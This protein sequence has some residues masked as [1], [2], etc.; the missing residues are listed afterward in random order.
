[1]QGGFETF[2][3]SER[4]EGCGSRSSFESH[5][6]VRTSEPRLMVTICRDITLIVGIMSIGRRPLRIEC[7]LAG[8]LDFPYTAAI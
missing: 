8:P 2:D 5:S 7:E 1:M 3:L 6:L 4:H